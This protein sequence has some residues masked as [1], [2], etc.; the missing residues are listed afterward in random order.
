MK[1]LLL[2]L[3]VVVSVIFSASC[4]REDV[5][6]AWVSVPEMKNQECADRIKSA[7]N[8]VKGVKGDLTEINL[9]DKTVLVVYESTLLSLK[10]VEFYIAEAGFSANEVPADK[11]ARTLLPA[12]CK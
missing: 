11:K 9:E 8:K 7:L 3:L 12:S 1:N 4:R 6:T 10:N 5:R 2:I